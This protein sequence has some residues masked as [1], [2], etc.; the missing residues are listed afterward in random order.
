MLGRDFLNLEPSPGGEGTIIVARSSDYL[1][2]DTHFGSGGAA[3]LPPSPPDTRYCCIAR[4]GRGRL[5]VTRSSRTPS[6]DVQHFLTRLLPDGTLDDS[7]GSGGVALLPEFGVPVETSDPT[8]TVR[9]QSWTPEGIAVFKMNDDG[10]PDATFGRRVFQ[11]QASRTTEDGG[12]IFGFPPRISGLAGASIWKI[13]SLGE[14]DASFGVSGIVAPEWPRAL[15][16]PFAEVQAGTIAEEPD[17]WLLASTYWDALDGQTLARIS[18]DGKT[19]Q[20]VRGPGGALSFIHGLP[21]RCFADGKGGAF[22][23]TDGS[24]EARVDT[25]VEFHRMGPD[26]T[27]D[28]EQPG[29]LFIFDSRN[30]FLSAALLDDEVLVLVNSFPTSDGGFMLQK[31]RIIHIPR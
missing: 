3:Q 28:R 30:D 23:V 27:V 10:S 15:A 31:H 18:P 21:L 6:G 29:R 26:G 7:F 12:T 1:S 5:L 8:G 14:L 25:N 11:T 9:L 20:L 19:V 17:G 13:D 24:D 4:D 2:V 16:R 22:F